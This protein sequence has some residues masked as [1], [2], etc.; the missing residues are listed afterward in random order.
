MLQRAKSSC[1]ILINACWRKEK[2]G[3]FAKKN[4]KSSLKVDTIDIKNSN[5]IH[6][7]FLFNYDYFYHITNISFLIENRYTSVLNLFS[8]FFFFLYYFFPSVQNFVL[9]T[10]LF[11]YRTLLSSRY[12]HQNSEP[13]DLP[14]DRTIRRRPEWQKFSFNNQVPIPSEQL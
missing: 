5:L 12:A 10:N 14:M 6:T 2:F 3:D 9:H 7:S 4:W 11:Y 1:K 13:D 8:I